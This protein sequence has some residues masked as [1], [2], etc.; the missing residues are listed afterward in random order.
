MFPFPLADIISSLVRDANPVKEGFQP[1]PLY[2]CVCLAV[3]LIM[4]VLA[5]LFS[6]AVMRILNKTKLGRNGE[7]KGGV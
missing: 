3:P 6:S 7:G 2:V 4:G 5:G 1:T